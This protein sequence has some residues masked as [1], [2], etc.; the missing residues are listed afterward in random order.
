MQRYVPGRHPAEKTRNSAK[1]NG[2]AFMQHARKER[3]AHNFCKSRFRKFMGDPYSKKAFEAFKEANN[4]LAV[5][6]PTDAQL[7]MNHARKKMWEL[8]I[9]EKDLK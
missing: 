3:R 5:E 6:N 7:F 4:R 1:P 2:N 9:S 8:A